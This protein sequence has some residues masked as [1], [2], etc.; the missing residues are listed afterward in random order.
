[1]AIGAGLCSTGSVIEKE[2]DKSAA[3]ASTHWAVWIHW[4]WTAILKHFVGITLAV[5][6]VSA[7]SYGF[8]VILLKNNG[9]VFTAKE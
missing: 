1:L 4:K 8:A 5:F 3:F 6:S 2:R 9:N 7:L